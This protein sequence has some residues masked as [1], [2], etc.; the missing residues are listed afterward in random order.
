MGDRRLERLGWGAVVGG[1]SV[2]TGL[3][4]SGVAGSTVWSTVNALQALLATCCIAM[5]LLGGVSSSRALAR[6]DAPRH[7]GSIVIG[8]LSFLAV[9]L[10]GYQ[11]AAGLRESRLVEQGLSL[12]DVDR[13]LSL[14]YGVWMVAL[15]AYVF[16]ELSG[17]LISRLTRVTRAVGA[18]SVWDG[19]R[20]Y[21][22]L[23]LAG[24]AAYFVAPPTP[25]Q[26]TFAA[27]GS[28]SGQGLFA[29]LAW[30]PALAVALAVVRRH[31]GSRTFVMVSISFVVLLI[32]YGNRSPLLLIA[33]AVFA[34]LLERQRTSPARLGAIV[35]AATLGYAGLV[36]LVAVGAWRGEII[37]GNEASLIGSVEDSARDPLARLTSAGVDTLD[38][39]ILSQYVDRDLVGASVTDPAKVLLGFIPHQVWADKPDWLSVTV[40]QN[41]LRFGA[42]GMFLSGPGYAR[43]VF[44]GILGVFIVFWALGATAELLTRRI[45]M[46]GLGFVLLMYLLTRFPFGGDAFD[47]FHVAGLYLVV[48]AAWA[49]QLGVALIAPARRGLL[50][51]TD[52]VAPIVDM[53]APRNPAQ[54]LNP[55]EGS[56][57]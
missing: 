51:P 45:G 32:T 2:A 30:T 24:I 39:L 5:V 49:L 54:R 3:A 1:L 19:R 15:A 52:A 47:L 43:L 14:A 37:R 40:A 7:V 26:T 28:E 36:G 6:G 57:T 10:P 20:T 46:C 9:V 44:G 53:P 23:V 31:F 4:A 41:Y 8:S 27:R 38:G 21:S 18:A 25:D 48:R 35:V 29:L 55:R 33:A 16:G 13:D 11:L 12:G 34:R 56:G 17:A 22:V 50:A 42:S